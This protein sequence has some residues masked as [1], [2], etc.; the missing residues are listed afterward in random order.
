MNLQELKKELP[1]K[2]RV[3]S[4]SKTSATAQ[5]VAYVDSRI[6]Q[7]LLD[8]VAGPENWQAEFYQVKNT[9]CCR[10]GIKINN[11]WV[12]KS[13]G[14]AETDIEAEKGELSDAFKRACVHWGIGR[15]L[16]ALEVVR[17]HTNGP[18][19]DSNKYPFVIDHAG[20]RV[21]DLT[22]FIQSGKHKTQ[23]QQKPKQEK[24]LTADEVGSVFTNDETKMCQK[25]GTEMAYKEGTGKTGKPYKAWFCESKNATH[26]IWIND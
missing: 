14:G 6:V 3:Q 17:V 16:Y 21:W 4:C 26:T 7:D 10:V 18:K 15:F 12:W 1:Y 8:E 13:D 9:M 20:Q 11:E 24:V 22:D 5:C 25:C 19:S 2:W 23:P